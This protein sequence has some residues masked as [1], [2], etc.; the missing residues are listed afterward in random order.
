MTNYDFSEQ[1]ELQGRHKKVQEKIEELL[2]DSDYTTRPLFDELKDSDLGFKD[3]SLRTILT[4]IRQFMERQDIIE[5]EEVGSGK[6]IPTHRWQLN[7]ED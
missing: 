5:V 7:K 2:E 4:D 3:S 1:E 6:G